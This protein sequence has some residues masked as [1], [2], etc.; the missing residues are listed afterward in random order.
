MTEEEEKFKELNEK[1]FKF[2]MNPWVFLKI[3]ESRVPMFLWCNLHFFYDSEEDI[4]RITSEI[5]FIPKIIIVFI[6]PFVFIISLFIKDMDTKDEM[7]SFW[8]IIFHRGSLTTYVVEPNEKVN[9]KDIHKE[10]IQIIAKKH[11][12]L[13]I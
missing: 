1:Y 5:N 2:K 10:M 11:P 3:I 13:V 12:E 8:N 7:V 4:I 9:E 6:I